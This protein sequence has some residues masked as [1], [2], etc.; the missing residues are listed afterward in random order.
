MDTKAKFRKRLEATMTAH[1]ELI[2]KFP[3]VYS[4]AKQTKLDYSQ[5]K[6]W[7]RNGFISDPSAWP[8]IARAVDAC[9]ESEIVL[10]LAKDYRRAKNGE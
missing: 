6:R 4:M 2:S 1:K 8:V 5:C 3:S 7:A 9:A 10:E